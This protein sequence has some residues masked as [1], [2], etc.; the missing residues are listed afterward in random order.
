MRSFNKLLIFITI[1]SI[2]YF[3]YNQL[4]SSHP[5]KIYPDCF[6]NIDTTKINKGQGCGEVFLYKE[7]KEGIL[8]V[9]INPIQYKLSAQCQTSS[10]HE[11]GILVNLEVY[12]SDSIPK[13]MT[14]ALDYCNDMKIAN[15]QDRIKLEAVSGKITSA[16]VSRSIKYTKGDRISVKL[17][18]LKFKD[19]QHEKIIHLSE[20]IFWNIRV[21]WRPG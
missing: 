20:E 18:D 4:Y 2:G 19:N 16:Y 14:R 17:S 15:A 5:D 7:L 6:M 11:Q 21:G 1:L 3:V 9:Y 12:P 10:I 8:T 13:G